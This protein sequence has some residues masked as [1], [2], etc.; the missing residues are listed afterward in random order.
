MNSGQ[1]KERVLSSKQQELDKVRME[2]LVM[3][4]NNTQMAEQLARI[5]KSQN[6]MNAKN[7]DLVR[8]LK[9][10]NMEKQ[11][12][13]SEVATL[14]KCLATA[15]A[16]ESESRQNLMQEQRDKLALKT[17]LDDL[18]SHSEKTFAKLRGSEKSMSDLKA[19]LGKVMLAKGAVDEDLLQSVSA[20]RQPAV[21][22]TDAK[23]A[24]RVR[25][26][27]EV[28]EK[29]KNTLHQQMTKSKHYDAQTKAMKQQLEASGRTVDVLQDLLKEKQE[30]SA[31]QQAAYY[32]LE[33]ALV[34]LAPPD[35][36]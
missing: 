1:A 28:I 32:V 18:K 3:R 27:Q 12:L 19:Q 11:Q 15:Q 35:I 17:E 14:K 36:V 25:A 9:D 13:M 4:Q 34:E 6:E 26:C 31:A 33:K 5:Q 16:C 20:V 23:L 21:M 30:A 7:Q 8:D 29:L 10:A 24:E 2:L 22:G